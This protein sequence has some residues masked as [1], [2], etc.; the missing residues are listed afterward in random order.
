MGRLQSRIKDLGEPF[1]LRSAYRQLVRRRSVTPN[2]YVGEIQA[3]WRT[4]IDPGVVAGRTNEQV[5]SYILKKALRKARQ[6]IN[7]CLLRGWIRL[8][9]RQQALTITDKGIGLMRRYSQ[10]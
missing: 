7:W 5:E 6:D 1:I 3:Y 2:E 8:D 10:A 4:Y 9:D